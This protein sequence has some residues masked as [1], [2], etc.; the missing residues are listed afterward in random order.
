MPGALPV[1]MLKLRFDWYGNY[2]NRSFRP[3]SCSP[4]VVSPR[5]SSLH[6]AIPSPRGKREGGNVYEKLAQIVLCDV[7]VIYVSYVNK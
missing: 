3:I 1:R 6:E 7:N 4:G 2:G 5:L